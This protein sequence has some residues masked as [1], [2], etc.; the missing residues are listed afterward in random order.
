MTIRKGEKRYHIGVGEGNVGNYIVLTGDIDRARKVSERFDSIAL[1]SANRE[2]NTYTGTLKGI[3]ISAMS[4]GIGPDNTEIAL[5]ELNGLAP[6][7]SVIIRCG[8]SGGLQRYA[9][10]GHLAVSTGAVRLE[11]TTLPYA[12][13]GFPAMPDRDVL[14][15]LMKC[16]DG[17]E[18]VHAGLTATADGFYAA[19]GRVVH[20][21]LDDSVSREMME[22]GV[23]NFEMETSAIF[24]LS[25][26]F[27]F[28]AGS[29]CGIYANRVTDEFA[30][31]RVAEI[32]DE[33]CIDLVIEA[34]MK[35]AEDD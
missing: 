14:S 8:S 29:V 1:T 4:T 12:M 17:R 20:P 28:R 21:N 2:Y 7:G 27:G 15:A 33:K 30:S 23:L 13:K 18:D 19:Q 35:L 9:K 3:G 25:K 5:V 24:I 22:L 11:R 16:S 10:V 6:K 34:I 31:H 26:A 32:T